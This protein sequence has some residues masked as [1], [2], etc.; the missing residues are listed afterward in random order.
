MSRQKS[1]SNPFVEKFQTQLEQCTTRQAALLRGRL[2]GLSK[3]KN[4]Q[5]QQQV[6]ERIAA[7]IETA[8]LEYLERQQQK[9]HISYPDELPVAQQ[10][11]DIKSAIEQNQVVV[12]A[13]ETGSG[14]TTQLPKM[15]LELGYGRKGTIGH[16]QPRRLAARSVAARIGEELQ[17]HNKTQVGYKIRFQDET[18]PTTAI[19][20]MT[21]GMLLSELQQDPLLLQYDAI[22]ID[23]AHE[24]SL[25]IDFLL[26]VLHT[27]LPK[28]RDLKLVITSATI[29]TERFSKHF[30]DAPVLTVT[31]RTYPVE[32]RYRPPKEDGKAA[33]ADVLQGVCE[34]V[35]ELQR[36]SEGD[37]LIF[38]SGEREIRDYAEAIGDL[39]LRSTEVL[40]LYAR[41]SSH[42]QNRVF[43]AHSQR[44][45]VIATN[46]AE[47]SLTVPG[48]RFVIDPGTARMSRYSYRTKVQR[49]PIEP[50]SQA[51]ANQRKGRCGRIGPGIC[52]RLYSEDDFLQ[53]PEYTDP[54]ILRTNLAAVILQMS[55]LRLGDIRQFPFV[56]KPDE[57]FV[58]DGLNLLE[59]LH[60]I[61]PGRKAERPQL[62]DTGRQLSRLPLDPRLARMV[63][64]GQQYGCVREMLVITAALSIQDPRERPH[65]AQQKADEWHQRFRDKSSD[66]MAFLNLWNYKKEQ[67]KALS[68]N[69]F[70]KQM[71]REFIHFMR[72]REWQDIYTQSR[73]TVREMGLSINDEAA[74]YEQVHRALI[75]GLLSQVGFKE[76]RHEYQGTRQS[77]FHIFPGSGLFG[78]PPKWVV[79]AEL[80]ETSKLY[81]RINADIDP[82][83]VEEAASHLVKK[84]YL[85]PHFEKKKGSV[86]A[87]EQVTLLGL[88]LVPRRR[89]QYGPVEPVKAREIFIREALVN[90]QLTRKLPFI[91]H[92]LKLISDIQALEAK[93]RRRDILV[94]EEVLFEAYDRAIPEGIYNEKLLAGW[95]HKAA[96]KEPKLLFFERNDLIAGETEHITENEYP[97]FWRQ[98]N[99]RLPLSYHF[100]PNAE[101]DGVSVNIQLGILNQVKL[102]GF[103]WHIPALREE[104]IAH[105]I[106]SLPKALRRN[107][108]PAPNFAGAIMADV[109][110]MH[111]RLTDAMATKLRRMT[112][113]TVPE[114]NWDES[115]LPAHLRMNFKI[116]D[117]KKLVSQGRDLQS[118][119]QQL[120]GKVQQRLEKTAGD[121]ISREQVD[122]W[123]FDDLPEVITERQQ[124]FE[125]KAYPGLINKGKGQVALQLFDNPEQAKQ[126]HKTGVR[127][128][129][130]QQI[131]SPVK[132]LQKSL[133]NK[134]K[135]AMYFNPWGKVDALIADCI[136][137]AVDGLIQEQIEQGNKLRDKQS[138]GQL[139]DVVRA[140]LNERVEKIALEVEQCL[141]L[142]Q[143]V[144]K[145]L[146]G[147]IPLDQI[148]SRGDIQDQLDNLVFAGFV[149]AYGSQRLSDIVRYLKAIQRRLEKLPVDPNKDRLMTLTLANLEEQYKAVVKAYEN[150][151]SVVP[152]DVAEIRW[153]IEELRVS[154][155]AQTLGTKYPV[156]EKR[157]K[158]AIEA[159]K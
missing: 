107:F 90:S 43:Q 118:L 7:D 122:S 145:A 59:E 158:Q 123:D 143:Q 21:D 61:E 142:S 65:D 74:T 84:Q 104:R 33:D 121:D 135:L 108:V 117:G 148:Q 29:E 86:I 99:L 25:N 110:P 24:R 48:I 26:G 124:G 83:W 159:A 15:L 155:F 62:T 3:I 57:R 46:V 49:L 79:T 131:P 18:A 140:N 75:A 72:L 130:L 77:R 11:N 38:A 152:D 35:E 17:D 19:K 106:K 97:E 120:S 14:K 150:K 69:Q 51:S 58:K 81:A 133:S 68:G 31:G 105:L 64:A 9:F 12:I 50:I 137:A 1:H 112:G 126:H 157:V 154:F 55:A 153:M 5:R 100:E 42:E 34:A 8:E 119:Q 27:L 146:K 82:L 129:L 147:K 45:V 73:Q 39:K 115:S 47:T 20:L 70:R 116:F 37:I 132:H 4:E 128:L 93:S 10:R 109:E 89:V 85:E 44:R 94:D 32:V 138:F 80:A 78:K 111:G 91:Q 41:L 156:S 53:R 134:A 67:Q 98:G 125:L 54:E 52:I 114:E 60:A 103:D 101:D 16:T 63:L 136:A 66:F 6:L 149:S 144:R 127:E 30:H 56:Q 92:N 139:K 113:V 141:L 36:E 88:I 40:P 102:E 151:G 13:G 87:D 28:R 76:D 96:K 71:G 23:E 95:W 2:R 22:I